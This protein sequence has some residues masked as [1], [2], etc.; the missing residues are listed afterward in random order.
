MGYLEA[1]LELLDKRQP[2]LAAALRSTPQNRVETFTSP[3]GLPSATYHLPD[4]RELSLHSKYDPMREARQA[5]RKADLAGADYFVLLGFG[6]GYNLDALVEH[7]T[8][9]DDSFFVVEGDLQVL[10]AA[11]DARDLQRVLSLPRLH[12]AWPLSAAEISE[13]WEKLFDP[14]R[15]QKSVI[16]QHFP[17]LAL[18]PEILKSAG[19]AI[20]SKTCQIFTDINTLISRSEVFLSNFV[21][22]L[23]WAL[24]SPGV[25]LFANSFEG[26]PAVIVSAGPSLDRNIHELR[27][28]DNRVLIL[29]TDTSL[30]PLLRIGVQPHFVLSGDPTYENYLHLAGAVSPETILVADSTAHPAALED[31]A[32]RTLTCT[33]ENS[34][35]RSLNTLLGPKGDLRAWGSVATMALDFAV[36][37]RC[38]PVIFIGQDLAHSD[39]RTY[40]SGLHFETTWFSEAHDPESWRQTWVSLRKGKKT[41]LMEDIFGFQV[42]STDKLIAYWN[43]INKELHSRPDVTFVNATEGGIL[44]DN[45]EIL[46]LRETLHRYCFRNLDLRTRVRNR[47]LEAQSKTVCPPKGMLQTLIRECGALDNLVNRAVHQCDRLRHEAAEEV[48]AILEQ[49]K[50]RIYAARHAAPILDCFNQ[51]GNITFLRRRAA[52]ARCA[53][54]PG[55]AVEAETMYRS[56]F[57]SVRQALAGIQSALTQI[58]SVIDS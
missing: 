17:S 26:V 1:N 49:F 22:N 54:A 47:F 27:G 16:I 45:V 40:C 50:E 7:S 52:L 30:K 56:Y 29:A 18:N 12:F 51:L 55:Y 37:L 33:F 19:D 44:R 41:V 43:W 6:L 42:E 9:P 34:S 23:R 53:G 5:I 8:N 35:L 13:Q 38:N 46:S 20:Q 15:A 11:F 39:G 25:A 10:R 3:S 31:Y 28:W 2:H 24:P 4:A 58:Q 32:G 36:Q 14:V 21:K 48:V 57:D